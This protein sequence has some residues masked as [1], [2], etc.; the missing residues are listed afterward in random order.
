MLPLTPNLLEPD[1]SSLLTPAVPIPA[2]VPL[3]PP[4]DYREFGDTDKTRS[5]IYNNVL[6]AAR[7]IQPISNE[8]H[9]LRLADVDYQDPDRVSKRDQKAA[10]LNGLTRGRRMRGTWELVDNQSQEV[11]DRKKAVLMTVPHLTERGTFI[12]NG[13]EYTLKNQQRLHP[14]AGQRRD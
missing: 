3:A 12:N 9:T 5:R 8:R 10:I 6:D 7:N 11:I 14:G 1:A 4:V 2:P 13:T